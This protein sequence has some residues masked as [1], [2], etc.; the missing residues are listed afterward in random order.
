[1]GALPSLNAL[2]IARDALRELWLDNKLA[3]Y[4]YEQSLA[5]IE[6]AI[7][8]RIVAHEAE[9]ARR[10]MDD[11]EV[12]DLDRDNLSGRWVETPVNAH[13]KPLDKPLH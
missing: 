2:Q 10:D 8:R 11:R 5:A 3:S 6:S 13:R 4:P 12:T 7:D 9:T 1:M